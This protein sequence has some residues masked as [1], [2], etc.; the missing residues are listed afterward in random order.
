MA[1]SAGSWPQR[2]DAGQAGIGAA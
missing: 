2:A 1:T